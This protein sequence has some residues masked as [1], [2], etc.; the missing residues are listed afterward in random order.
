M[1]L[2][3]SATKLALV[4]INTQV[5]GRQ[6][7]QQPNQAIQSNCFIGLRDQFRTNNAAFIHPIE[8]DSFY[9]HHPIVIYLCKQ[10]RLKLDKTF[11]RC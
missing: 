10:E 9:H 11:N 4:S 3:L 2:R 8:R 7:V 6:R 5:H 1:D